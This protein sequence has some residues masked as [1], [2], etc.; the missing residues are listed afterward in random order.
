[1]LRVMVATLTLFAMFSLQLDAAQGKA[2]SSADAE[3]WLH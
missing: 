2:V 1:M 3:A